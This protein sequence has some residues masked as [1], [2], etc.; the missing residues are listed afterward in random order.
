MAWALGFMGGSYSL[1]NI[2]E[3]DLAVLHGAKDIR[4]RTNGYDRIAIGNLPGD[5]LHV[6]LF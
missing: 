4:R 3:P 5:I 1:I 6:N 2:A